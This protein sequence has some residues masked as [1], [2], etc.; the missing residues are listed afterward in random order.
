MTHY[1]RS[2]DFVLAL[3][4]DAQDLIDG[5][6]FALGALSHYA[7]DNDGHHFATNLAVP[8]LYPKLGRKFGNDVTYEQDPQLCRTLKRRFGFDILEVAQGRYA[9]DAYHDFH[10]LRSFAFRFWNKLFQGNV[11]A[12]HIKT[13]LPR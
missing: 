7:A 12:G 1:V 2:G 11:R 13:V 6:A 9:P 8:I 4:Q 5:Y 10:R 3:L